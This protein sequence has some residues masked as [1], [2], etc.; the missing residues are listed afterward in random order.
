MRVKTE[1]KTSLKFAHPLDLSRW[2]TLDNT[3]WLVSRNNLEQLETSRIEQGSKFLPRAF[4]P[5]CHNQHVQVDKLGKM[6]F[7]RVWN[8]AVDDDES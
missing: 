8:N 1:L 6:R 7:I 4:L 3:G 2:L 5:A